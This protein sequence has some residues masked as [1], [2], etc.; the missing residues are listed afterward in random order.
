VIGRL[1]FNKQQ[2]WVKHD[3]HYHVDFDVQCR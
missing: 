1:G 2:A 3:E